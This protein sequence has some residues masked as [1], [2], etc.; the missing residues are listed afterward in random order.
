VTAAL[1]EVLPALLL[2]WAA[3]L[4]SRAGLPL[5]SLAVGA[6][7][8]LLLA[9]ARAVLRGAASRAGLGGRE[10]GQVLERRLLLGAEWIAALAFGGVALAPLLPDRRLPAAA[11]LAA[12]GLL[13]L[14]ALAEGRRRRVPV[15]RGEERHWKGGLVYLNPRDRQLLVP[16]RL[17]PGYTLNLGRPLSWALLLAAL[18]PPVLLAAWLARVLP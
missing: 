13:L 9:A 18:A 8:C 1:R 16:A 10:P 17:G 12:T 5:A 7:L 15:P 6:A 11:A 14:L 3:W 4:A 2:A